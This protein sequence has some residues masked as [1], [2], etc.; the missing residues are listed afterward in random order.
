[1]LNLIKLS[2]WMAKELSWYLPYALER[3]RN[4]SA[5]SSVLKEE[6]DLKETG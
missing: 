6:Y 2:A 1:M 4:H 5:D 3:Y